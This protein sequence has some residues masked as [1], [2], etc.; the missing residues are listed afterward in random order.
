[1]NGETMQIQM[2]VIY[3]IY[4]H[5]TEQFEDDMV[6]RQNGTLARVTESGVEDVK[7]RNPFSVLISDNQQDLED[8]KE[9]IRQEVIKRP[10][11]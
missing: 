1:M 10:M 6:I 2:P 3:A 8:L 5:W 11:Q 4:N 7:D 9:Y